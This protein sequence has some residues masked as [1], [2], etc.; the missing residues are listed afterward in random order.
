MM[1]I[2][3][4]YKIMTKGA[5]DHTSEEEIKEKLKKVDKENRPLRI[6]LGLDPS[7]PDIHLGHAVVLRKI[8]QLQ[9]LGHEAI[10]II[11]DFTGMIG[12]PTGKSKTRKPLSKE[13]VLENAQTYQDQI[14]KVI[15]KDQTTVR[16]NSEWLNALNFKDVI[17]LASKCTVARMLE[18]D[19]FSNRYKNQQSISLHEFFYPLM[20]AYDS[21]AIKADVELGG[22]DQ[23]F[24][25][26]MGRN[27]QRDFN[28]DPQITLFMPLLE[29]TD[30]VEKMSKSLGNYIGIDDD[31]TTMYT[32]VMKIPDNMIIKYYELCTDL[33][34]DKIEEI[35]N[36]LDNNENPRDIKMELALEITR[37]YHSE[38]EAIKAEENFKT[39][40]QKQQATEDTVE[41]EFDSTSENITSAVLDSILSSGEYKSKAEIKRL[42]QQG[43]MKINGER[44]DSFE[45]IS[46][47]DGDIILQIG[48]GRFY[49]LV[50]SK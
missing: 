12:D 24:N 13:Q 49:K 43:A 28:Q 39:L 46:D 41:L 42:L 29:G 44:I 38:E 31:A 21:V 25:I 6:K 3:E 35:K 15:N 27:I 26:N 2:E 5:A 50:A 48:K 10:I 16:Y 37:L 19:D 36:R 18:R 45:N 32:K 4:T 17:E 20:Q 47:K 23:T 8:R 11:G 14:F 30:G 22:T 40:F 7:A 34:P 1:N 9:D 33:H